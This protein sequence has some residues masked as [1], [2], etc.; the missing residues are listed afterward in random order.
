MP[1]SPDIYHMA[2]CRYRRPAPLVERIGRP[3]YGENGNIQY[4]LT[5][6]TDKLG[7]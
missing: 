3:P 6:Q 4:G 2:L 5:F 1:V 7:D